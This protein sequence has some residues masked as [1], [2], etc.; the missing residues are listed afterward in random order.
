VADDVHEAGPERRILRQASF[1]AQQ[2]AV[3]LAQNHLAFDEQ[4]VLATRG[5]LH[6]VR[7]VGIAPCFRELV[8]VGGEVGA[9]GVAVVD[10]FLLALED[11][12]EDAVAD[13][14][15]SALADDL[16]LEAPVLQLRP[17]LEP[18]LLFE[19][20]TPRV[21]A[22]IRAIRAQRFFLARQEPGRSRSSALR[23]SLER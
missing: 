6:D 8:I 13:R 10:Q 22:A 1:H 23:L 19:A 12:A 9:P 21:H 14:V 17:R 11:R 16:E 7:A 4:H 2:L 5:D 15:G 20:V 3:V 18:R